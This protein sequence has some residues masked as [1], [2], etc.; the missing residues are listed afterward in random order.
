MTRLFP[1]L[2]LL[3]ALAGCTTYKLWSEADAD[4][5]VGMVKLSYE[6]RK[7]ENP[8]VDERAAIETA[9]E[10]C[11]GWGYPDARRKAEERICRDGSDGDCRRWEVIREYRCAEKQ[12]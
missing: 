2:W 1:V 12:R 6:Y 10:R 7:F 4:Q 9:R 5:D 8:M 11:R 3:T